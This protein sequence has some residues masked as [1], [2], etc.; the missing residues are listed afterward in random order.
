MA[1]PEPGADFRRRTVHGFAWSAFGAGLL[2]LLGLASSIVLA[3]LL[4]PRD[5]GL[6]AMAVAA[7]GFLQLLTREGIGT[8]LVRTPNADDDDHDAAFWAGL[9]VGILLAVG[10]WLAAPLVAA[11]FAEPSLTGILRPL[12]ALFALHGLGLVPRAQLTRA[13]DFR[14]LTLIEAVASLG[15]AAAAIAMAACGFGVTSLL[16]QLLL[17]AAL[18]NV[19]AWTRTPWR[20]RLRFRM[21]RLAALLAFS[22]SIWASN[23]LNYVVRNLDDVLVGR[24]LGSLAL[25]L[26]GRAYRLMLLPLR[27]LSTSLGSVL[28]P[29]L[30][31]LQN[32]TRRARSLYLRTIGLI[33][34]VTAPMAI[35]MFAVADDFVLAVLGPQWT[36]CVPLLRILCPLG[37]TQ[38]VLTTVGALYRSQGRPD[39]ELRVG[40]VLKTALVVGIVVGLQWGVVGVAAGYAI[41]SLVNTVPAAYFPGRLVGIRLSDYG[42]AV[43]GPTLGAV[44][45]GGGVLL[46]SRGLPTHWPPVARLGV[47]AAAG[48]A[49]Y[50]ALAAALRLHAVRELR[51]L[52]RDHRAGPGARLGQ[53]DAVAQSGSR[54]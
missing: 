32:D 16:V 46:L 19:A 50:A 27:T 11:A 44:V 17:G 41:A 48:I 26:Y 25:G 37:L 49:L 52:W 7:A 51:Q 35:G 34:F 47:E 54:P 36:E 10:W 14:S 40:L 6:I 38:S 28:F 13:L 31:H 4:T 2:Q 12:A 42:R 30:S 39:L 18:S 1:T 29:S 45:M 8:A 43:A 21:Q 3:R 33:S 15:A 23:A 5:F 53:A 24:Y 22:R 20:P 9:A